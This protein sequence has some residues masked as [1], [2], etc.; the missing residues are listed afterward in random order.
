M[1]IICCLFWDLK[2]WKNWKQKSENWIE[3]TTKLFDSCQKTVGHISE[4][5]K[6]ILPPAS[7]TNKPPRHFLVPR[8]VPWRFLNG[9]GWNG[10]NKP[11]GDV[12]G[13]CGW[14]K[15]GLTPD[16]TNHRVA[17]VVCLVIL[18]WNLIPYQIRGHQNFLWQLKIGVGN[19]NGVSRRIT[20]EPKPP[21]HLE[22]WKLAIW[23]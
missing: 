5:R 17:L 15:S 12:C 13:I 7:Q 18:I 19:S 21:W 3:S 6:R 9:A 4:D 20:D 11:R 22:F 14:T 1:R 10:W 8:C 23:G 2:N 16:K